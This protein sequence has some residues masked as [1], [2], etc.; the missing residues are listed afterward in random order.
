[1]NYIVM[2]F[3]YFSSATYNGQLSKTNS[4]CCHEVDKISRFVD[5]YPKDQTQS[6]QMIIYFTLTSDFIM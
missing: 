2:C 3:I 6:V 1:M 5:G 4:H